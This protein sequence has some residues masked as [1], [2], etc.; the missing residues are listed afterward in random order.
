MTETTLSRS[1]FIAGLLTG[2]IAASLFVFGAFEP[3]ETSLYDSQL[4]KT[5]GRID[6]RFVVMN[7]GREEVPHVSDGNGGETPA[8]SSLPDV[9]ESLNQ[10]D[11][12][13][14]VF[15]FPVDGV[16]GSIGSVAQ[17]AAKHGSVVF[18][19]NLLKADPN[20]A[21]PHLS[22]H[23]ELARI[24]IAL[25]YSGWVSDA[26]GVL[27]RYH[28]AVGQEVDLGVAAASAAKSGSVSLPKAVPS[29]E[30]RIGPGGPQ[31]LIPFVAGVHPPTVDYSDISEKDIR[32]KTV[33]VRSTSID[34]AS[35][36]TT[37][38]GAMSSAEVT[39]QIASALLQERGI[40]R[41]PIWLV[42]A[43]LIGVSGAMTFR[44]A[45]PQIGYDVLLPLA[46]GAGIWVIG[47]LALRQGTW[48]DTVPLLALLAGQMILI[49]AMRALL[50]SLANRKKAEEKPAHQPSDQ[51]DPS[52]FHGSML[53][54]LLA[55]CFAESGCIWVEM[56]EG[57]QIVKSMGQ[58][59]EHLV[60]GHLPEG[61]VE[62]NRDEGQIVWIP[63]GDRHSAGAVLVRKRS[64]T[65]ADRRL[66]LVKR[67]ATVFAKELE[68]S[69]S[70]P[71]GA[72]ERS[73]AKIAV[74]VDEKDH[75]PPDHPDVLA[76]IAREIA[77]KAAASSQD[78]ETLRKA[79][80]LHD[81]GKIGVPDLVLDNAHRLSDSEYEMVK[82]HAI[83]AEEILTASGLSTEVIA[84]VGGHHE[85]WDGRG[86]PR[87]VKGEDI[88]TAAR[89]LAIA[90]AIASM[91]SDRP[92]RKGMS[93]EA[94]VEEIANQRARMF[95]PWLVEATV[96]LAIERPDIFKRDPKRELR[97]PA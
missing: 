54:T 6:G 13:V 52:V 17:A 79:C 74:I 47:G 32:G 45:R 33:I 18:S 86:Y 87:A 3:L 31:L 16:D 82:R 95:D 62:S 66:S 50:P 21:G 88:P 1:I 97:E 76:E 40:T 81:I 46:V 35:R 19:G 23:P 38:V 84:A 71:A 15:N 65:L 60:E 94:A 72:V 80:L 10:N 2:L 34:P 51:S 29:L 53:Q 55:A 26:D 41:A 93:F 4:A 69:T 20:A 92:Y 48:I 14:I 44:A 91:I 73:L 90:D 56:S 68:S 75:F 24:A 85:R 11:A 7:L 61:I 37:P 30:R 36:W 22:V 70:D 42:V 43:A 78:M 25:G 58:V 59:S 77:R 57:R 5:E 27:R 28:P 89:I 49:P 12:K 67:V 39:T 83:V 9:I 64:V 96:E 8:A 63:I